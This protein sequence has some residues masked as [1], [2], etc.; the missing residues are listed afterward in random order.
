MGRTMREGRLVTLFLT[1]LLA[2]CG[3]SGSSGFDVAPGLEATL[4]GRAIAENR[5]VEGDGLL[6]CPSGVPAPGPD[7]GMNVPGPSEVRVEAGLAGEVD[8]STGSTCTLPVTVSTD[9]LPEGAQIRIAVRASDADVWQVGEPIEVQ[10]SSGG[11]GTVTPVDVEL[12]GESA[13]GSEAQAAVLVFLPPIGVV[14][15]QVQELRETGAS[16]AFVVA[17]F[18]LSPGASF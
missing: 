17:P 9:G 16:Y 6:I 5:C 10:S 2:A 11:D 18:S 1:V 15:T 8:C 14:P 12:A 7:N 4:I 13:P 3:G